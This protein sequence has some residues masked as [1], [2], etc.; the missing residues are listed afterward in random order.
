MNRIL[1]GAAFVAA[2]AYSGYPA[3][4]QDGREAQMIG[5]RDF[6]EHGDKK[7]CVKF[8]MMLQQNIDRQGEW[9]HSHPD[10]F[11]FEH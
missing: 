2:L 5:F 6:C 3:A 10:W 11:F 1:I 9:R 7:A 8:G 4:A